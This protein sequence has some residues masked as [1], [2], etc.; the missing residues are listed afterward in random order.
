MVLRICA[1]CNRP[2]GVLSRLTSFLN[3]HDR[4]SHGICWSCKE[5]QVNRLNNTTR[6]EC[7]NET[8]PITGKIKNLA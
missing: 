6:S 3:I 8:S 5:E 2:I 4:T 7:E 1:W